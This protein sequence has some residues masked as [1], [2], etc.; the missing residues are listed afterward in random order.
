MHKELQLNG[1]NNKRPL[2]KWA[3]NMNR[4]FIKEIEMIKKVVKNTQPP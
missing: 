1:T 4:Q 2:D 3:K